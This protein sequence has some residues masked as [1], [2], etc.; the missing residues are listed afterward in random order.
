MSE[1]QHLEKQKEALKAVI[2]SYIQQDEARF[3]DR[4]RSAGLQHITIDES[5]ERL[6]GL[7]EVLNLSMK[8]ITSLPE[9]LEPGQFARIKPSAF[10]R[11]GNKIFS[12][13]A[14][15]KIM[16]VGLRED[17]YLFADEYV[18]GEY[19]GGSNDFDLR[20]VANLLIQ[21]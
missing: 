13:T 9:G 7:V 21:T 5:R 18:D 6:N 1:Q 17:Q 4:K 20:Q 12:I 3:L 11:G 19:K 8:E 10:E 2:N 15:D 14:G 16:L